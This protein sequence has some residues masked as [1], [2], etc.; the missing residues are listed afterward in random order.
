M[1]GSDIGLTGNWS[2]TDGQARIH[3]ERCGDSVCAVNTWVKDP[4]KGELVGD[5]FV[6]TVRPRQ[7]TTLAGEAFDVR[8]G[9]TYSFLI[10]LDQDAM[11]TK[12][13]L[14]ASVVCRTMNW[15]RVP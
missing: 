14:V 6:M 15:V 7:P 11:T 13:C 9:L 12:G 2:R 8:R 3:I 1:A 5:R 10:S 4:A